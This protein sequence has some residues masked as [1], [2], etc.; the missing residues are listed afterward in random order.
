VAVEKN[1]LV[2]LFWK[3]HPVL[4]RLSGGRIGGRLVGMPV[5]LLTTTGRR[6]GQPRERALTYLPQ[7]DAFV[8][9]ASYLGQPRHPDWY[10]NLRAA[11]RATVRLGG[12][13]LEVVAREAVDEE[14]ERLWA[15]VVRVNPDYEEY[16][17]R[18]ARQI[19]V[20]VLEPHG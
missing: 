8:V 6:S 4:Y 5:L 11:P 17:R 2:E 19:P 10:W 15:A 18:T 20:L 12:K 1:K 13:T 14:R 7:G 16:K 3:V 9:I